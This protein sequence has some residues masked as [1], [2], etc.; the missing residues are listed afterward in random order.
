MD[1]WTK[2]RWAWKRAA[3]ADKLLSAP[4]KILARALVDNWANGKTGF[5]NPKVQTMAD[6]LGKDV[7][8]IQRA[9][10][11]LE[12]NGWITV[13]HQGRA[14]S[15]VITFVFIVAESATSDDVTYLAHTG[16]DSHLNEADL[17][18]QKGDSSVTN[19]GTERVTEH[20]EKGDSSVTPSFREPMCEPKA[21]AHEAHAQGRPSLFKGHL[22]RIEEGSFQEAD[23]NGYLRRLGLAG[24]DQL[25]LAHEGFYLVPFTTPPWLGDEIG[26]RIA[27]KWAS[28]MASTFKA[29]AYA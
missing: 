22:V 21:H 4:A 13:R 8:S 28:G 17:A 14:K 27:Q 2:D 10:A 29:R 9:L 25:A 11:S 5:C 23:W 6:A 19:S 1:N 24:L 3:I 12:N 7:R 26:N 16:A 15:S 18:D 20:V